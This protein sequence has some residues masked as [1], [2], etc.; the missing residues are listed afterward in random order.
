MQSADE[1]WSNQD[2]ID[3]AKEVYDSVVPLLE[4]EKY[5]GKTLVRMTI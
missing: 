1:A 4:K 3:W 2:L 5:D